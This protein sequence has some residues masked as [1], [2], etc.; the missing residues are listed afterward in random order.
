MQYVEI[1]ARRKFS[2]ISPVG[3]IGK[4]FFREYFPRSVPQSVHPLL[5]GGYLNLAKYHNT[6]YAIGEI[7]SQ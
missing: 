7:F 1:F 2:P 6:K 5:P 4:K 3:I